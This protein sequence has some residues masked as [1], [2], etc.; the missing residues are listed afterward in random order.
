MHFRFGPLKGWIKTHML[1]RHLNLCKQIGY[2]RIL[3]PLCPLAHCIFLHCPF[4]ILRTISKP[5]FATKGYTQRPFR[6]GGR[7]DS[8]KRDEEPGVGYAMLFACYF[9]I[10]PWFVRRS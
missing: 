4:S 2:D 9:C 3:H 10:F 1:L 5:K 8:R 6:R 7:G